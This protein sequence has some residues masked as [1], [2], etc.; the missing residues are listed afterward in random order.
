MP[1]MIATSR[2][3]SLGGRKRRQAIEQRIDFRRRGC[4][5]DARHSRLEIVERQVVAR[6]VLAERFDDAL[7]DLFDG[8]RGKLPWIGH[9]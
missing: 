2:S 9:A 1:D 5:V 7:T 4:G 8:S 6:E 3:R